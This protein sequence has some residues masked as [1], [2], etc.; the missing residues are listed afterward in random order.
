MAI[1]IVDFPMKNG[2]FPPSY[3][4]VYQRVHSDTSYIQVSFLFPW[5]P[6]LK[7]AFSD[8]QRRIESK[9][10]TLVQSYMAH[11]TTGKP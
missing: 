9:I 7:H 8:S 1:E 4:T 3:G 6:P 2:G 5:V 10:L 11:C